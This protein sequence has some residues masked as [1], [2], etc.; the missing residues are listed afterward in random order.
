L[1]DSDIDTPI[2][3]ALLL[4]G[5]TVTPRACRLDE[6]IRIEVGHNDARESVA[7]F[8]AGAGTLV[9]VLLLAPLMLFLYMRKELGMA[10]VGAL[11]AC[12][13]AFVASCVVTLRG[14]ESEESVRA[15]MNVLAAQALLEDHAWAVDILKT[16]K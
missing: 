11:L 12:C 14:I 4:T 15:R 13:A 1:R 7:D 5:R 10:V 9:F 16:R 3:D 6:E 8:M 2:Q